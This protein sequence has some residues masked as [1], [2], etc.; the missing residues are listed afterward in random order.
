MKKLTLLAA[1]LGLAVGVHAQAL[2]PFTAVGYDQ[3]WDQISGRISLGAN[4]NV[5]VGINVEYNDALADDNF[6]FG[7]S[8]VYL[9]NLHNWGPVSNHLALGGNLHKNEGVSD[10]TVT[11]VAGLQ[12]EVL[13][14]DRILLSTRFGLELDVAPDVGLR[15]V[16]NGVSIVSGASFKI[17]F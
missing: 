9:H 8:G 3:A 4:A 13:L 17:V 6:G 1:A 12:P 11:V 7:V 5:D 10:I 15:T 2:G 16:G 14:L